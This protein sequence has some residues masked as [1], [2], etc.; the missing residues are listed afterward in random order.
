MT[1]INLAQRA[2]IGELTVDEVKG[3]TKEKL[4]KNK[5]SLGYTV[6]CFTG[7]VVIVQ[8]KLLKQ[9]LIKTS[10]LMYSQDM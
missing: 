3:A 1:S 5:D 6:P 10:I 8:V 2:K 9:F 4:E 7:Q